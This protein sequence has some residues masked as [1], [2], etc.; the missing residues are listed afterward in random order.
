MP[1][2]D[3]D[4]NFV[5]LWPKVGV[6]PASSGFDVEVCVL[7]VSMVAAAVA[8]NLVEG[9]ACGVVDVVVEVVVEVEINFSV[10]FSIALCGVLL[11]SLSFVASMSI[12]VSGSS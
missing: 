4:S 3:S 5:F 8:V 12:P 2:S 6:L 9:V 11:V 1:Q 7:E 10:R